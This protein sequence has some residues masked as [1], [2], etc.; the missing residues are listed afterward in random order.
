MSGA[1]RREAGRHNYVTPTSY[2]ELISCFAT[3]LAQRRAKVLAQQQKY[4]V[5]RGGDTPY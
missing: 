5:R 4:E 1:F 3:L 2:L